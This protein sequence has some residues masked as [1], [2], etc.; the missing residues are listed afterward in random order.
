MYGSYHVLFPLKFDIELR[1]VAEIPI[2]GTADK[3]DELS[4]SALTSEAETMRLLK[5]E[6]TIPLPN[7][8]DFSPTPNNALGC[9]YIIMSFISG[10]PLYGV[11]FGQRLNGASHEAVRA[12]EPV[13]SIASP[14]QWFN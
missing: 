13:L 7:V 11:W 9:P 3:W 2:N 12:C 4:A 1:L 14:Q 5:R 6:T 10:A 8:L